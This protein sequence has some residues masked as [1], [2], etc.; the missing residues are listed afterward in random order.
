MYCLTK[1]EHIAF[2]DRVMYFGG[3]LLLII[4]KEKYIE[5]INLD[6]INNY[7]NSEEFKNKYTSSKNFKISQKNLNECIIPKKYLEI[8]N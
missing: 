4:P 7:F 5:R 2:K 3:N 8:N 6:L 1:N